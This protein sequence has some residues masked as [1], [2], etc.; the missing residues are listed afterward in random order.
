MRLL[1]QFSNPC[2]HLLLNLIPWPSVLIEEALCLIQ[3]QPHCPKSSLQAL[4]AWHF[5]QLH[6]KVPKPKS[7]IRSIILLEC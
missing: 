4:M 3:I 2:L 5:L 6:H 7:I 1:W